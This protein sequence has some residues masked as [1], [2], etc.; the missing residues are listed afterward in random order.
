M[1]KKESLYKELKLDNEALSG[2]ELIEF[3]VRY[4]RLMER[5]IVLHK[6]KCV[7]GRPPETV[8]SILK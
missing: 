6:G 2:E 3:M 4:P 1:R 5:P 8:L 7:I